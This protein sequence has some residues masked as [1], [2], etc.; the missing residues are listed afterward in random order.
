MFVFRGDIETK[1]EDLR[2]MVGRR[3]RDIIEAAD[4][5]RDMK[6]MADHVCF[7]IL[8]AHGQASCL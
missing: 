6:Q 8:V 3:Y 7:Q 2:Q 5:I 1:K 4:N